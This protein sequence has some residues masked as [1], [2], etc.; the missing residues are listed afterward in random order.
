MLPGRQERVVF[1]LGL[2]VSDTGKSALE[3]LKS[4]RAEVRPMLEELCAV[5]GLSSRSRLRGSRFPDL[6]R[7]ARNP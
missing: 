5:G 4:I 1:H 7:A 3:A 6:R 2:A